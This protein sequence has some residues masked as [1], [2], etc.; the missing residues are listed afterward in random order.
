MIKVYWLVASVS[1]WVALYSYFLLSL[2]YSWQN[3][4]A[5][6]KRG[7]VTEEM[8]QTLLANKKQINKYARAD[9]IIKPIKLRGR[10]MFILTLSFSL[11]KIAVIYY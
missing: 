1:E 10:N 2:A 4:P 11:K 6:G 7:P 8:S 9:N 3:P 5:N